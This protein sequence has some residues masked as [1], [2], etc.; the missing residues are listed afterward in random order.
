MNT[1]AAKLITSRKEGMDTYYEQMNAWRMPKKIGKHEKITKGRPERKNEIK[2]EQQV[3][4]NVTQKDEHGATMER[5]PGKTTASRRGLTA[6]RHLHTGNFQGRKTGTPRP[7]DNT[8]PLKHAQP[9]NMTLQI[10]SK[11][12]FGFENVRVS[13]CESMPKESNCN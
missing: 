5:E 9:V 7:S 4:K 12:K 10:L 6:R 1:L 2:T 8:L 3:K 11:S 13:T